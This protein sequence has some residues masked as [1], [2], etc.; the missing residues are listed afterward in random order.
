VGSQPDPA[1]SA[2]DRFE[3]ELDRAEVLGFLDQDR[4]PPDPAQV[5]AL[6]AIPQVR[7]DND[8]SDSGNIRPNGAQFTLSRDSND[9]RQK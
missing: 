9:L 8:N 6:L 7:Y 5:F 4:D 1:S 3:I 2:Q